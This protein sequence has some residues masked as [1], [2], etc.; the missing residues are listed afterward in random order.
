MAYSMPDLAITECGSFFQFFLMN[1]MGSITTWQY[2]RC[3]TLG[4]GGGA[5]GAQGGRCRGAAP[6]S[7]PAHLRSEPAPSRPR[8]T[9]SMART[10]LAARAP[11]ARLRALRAAVASCAREG[12]PRSQLRWR[13]ATCRRGHSGC[14]SF[15]KRAPPSSPVLQQSCVRVRASRCVVASKQS[16]VTSRINPVKLLHRGCPV[17]GRISR[18]G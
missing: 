7:Q 2:S 18:K 12:P 17:A 5:E 1:I 11:G 8:R 6:R 10:R 13:G 16:C 9:L 15:A 3:R 14:T 4:G